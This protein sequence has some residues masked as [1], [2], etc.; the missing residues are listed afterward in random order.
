MS[1]EVGTTHSFRKTFSESDVYLFGGIICDSSPW[2]IDEEFAKNSIFKK[3]LV[4]GMLTASMFSTVIGKFFPGYIYL[5]QEVSFRKPVFIGDTIEA[6]VVVTQ[7]DEK[8][9]VTLQCECINQGGNQV[10][11]GTGLIKKL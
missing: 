9:K 2:H 4:Y 5:S 1:P 10:L 3:R 6:K 11:T 8:G 7:V